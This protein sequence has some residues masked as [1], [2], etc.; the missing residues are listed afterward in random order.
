MLWLLVR[1]LAAILLIIA[2][3][4]DAVFECRNEKSI[5]AHET[6]AHTEIDNRAAGV[7]R[8]RP[9][10]LASVWECLLLPLITKVREIVRVARPAICALRTQGGVRWR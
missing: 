7:L 1:Q 6:S 2:A 9:Q 5:G 10:R 4:N 3:L 8:T